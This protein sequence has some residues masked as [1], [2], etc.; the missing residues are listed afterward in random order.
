M[1]NDES[2]PPRTLGEEI[3]RLLELQLHQTHMIAG[4]RNPDCPICIRES[5]SKEKAS[6]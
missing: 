3:I 1:N 6:G 2:P 4:R 5:E